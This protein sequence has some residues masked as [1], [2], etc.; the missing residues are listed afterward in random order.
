MIDRAFH[1][2]AGFR[3][4]LEDVPRPDGEDPRIKVMDHDWVFRQCLLYEFGALASYLGRAP[5]DLIASSDQI[6]EWAA[7]P[8]GDYPVRPLTRRDHLD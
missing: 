8:M 6:D 3:G 5:A 2:V 7:A 1:V 4:G